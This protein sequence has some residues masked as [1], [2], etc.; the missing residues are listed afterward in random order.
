MK[1]FQIITKESRFEPAFEGD[2]NYDFDSFFFGNT[3]ENYIPMELF[4]PSP[5][6]KRL[7]LVF[8]DIVRFHETTPI[9]SEKAVEVMKDVLLDFG[10]IF[11]V[12]TPVGSYY[13]YNCTNIIDALD[14]DKSIIKYIG[15][16]KKYSIGYE[17]FEFK[18]EIVIGQDAFRLKDESELYLFISEN[19]KEL[20]ES[21]GL[22]GFEFELAWEG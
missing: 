21:A 7:N 9:L 22:T 20:V 4:I 19:I 18:K 14:K 6:N 17:K 1:I 13:I 12:L 2:V 10:Q 15:D 5:Q 8:T 11:P 3:I 16:S